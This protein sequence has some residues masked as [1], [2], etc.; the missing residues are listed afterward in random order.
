MK[1]QHAYLKIVIIGTSH[2]T[3]QVLKL[4]C[5]QRV[6]PQCLV[7]IIYWPSTVHTGEA[8]AKQLGINCIVSYSSEE[9]TDLFCNIKT[10]TLVISAGNTY[11]FPEAVVMNYNL[12]IINFHN[13]LLPAYPG[14]NIPTWV[15]Y[16]DE[17]QTG[18]SWHAIDC[19]IDSGDIFIQKAYKIGE[20]DTAFNVLRQG[21]N[22]GFQAFTEIMSGVIDGTLGGKAQRF[23]SS[24]RLFKSDER[25]DNGIIN[26]D[27]NLH[28]IYRLLRSMDYG[29][30][31]IFLPP[32][33]TFSKKDYDVCSYSLEKT[34][35]NLTKDIHL[36]NN[37]LYISDEQHVLRLTLQS[38]K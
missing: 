17:K 37:V 26:L 21:M 30:F 1:N 34:E 4:L 28:Y 32:Q 19:G 9:L 14:Q 29:R 15:I 8:I 6:A 3:N 24:R 11:I 10:P 31:N 22:A 12:K 25:P 5:V 13:S 38:K 36:K 2:I 18:I 16:G 7:R 33:L 27:S 35:I 23:S 20:H